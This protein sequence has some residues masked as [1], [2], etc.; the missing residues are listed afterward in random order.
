MILEV[1]NGRPKLALRHIGYLKGSPQTVILTRNPSMRRP[2]VCKIS[3]DI[4]CYVMA[5]HLIHLVSCNAC[6]LST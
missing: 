3:T 5:I 1:T 4:L 6:E 2:E